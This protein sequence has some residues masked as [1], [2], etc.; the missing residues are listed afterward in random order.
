[1]LERFDPRARVALLVAMSAAAL[2][3]QSWRTLMGLAVLSVSLLLAAR[4]PWARLR[5]IW[6]GAALFIAIITGVNMLVRTP[7]EAA[8][9]ALRAVVMLGA[10]LAVVL[11]FDPALLGV[12]FHQLG[13][14]DRLAFALDLTV[15][16][17]PMLA[18][19]FRATIDAQRARGYELELRHGWR[20]LFTVGRRLAPLIVPVVVRAVLDAE[21]RANAMDLRAF[22]S[23]PRTWLRT[24][25]FAPR[26]YGL[27]AL[28]LA[29]VAASVVLR[30]W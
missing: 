9:Q 16:F 20:D 12:T 10:P 1:M 8:Q 11:T 14:P 17:T 3:A 29:V 25:R 30:A 22:G 4:V 15:R 19:D 2:I 27:L 23:G 21:D 18:R 13:L 26:D 6:T 5:S 24:L 28:S 7:Q